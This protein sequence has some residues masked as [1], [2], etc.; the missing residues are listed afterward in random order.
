MNVNVYTGHQQTEQ[1]LTISGVSTLTVVADLLT[2]ECKVDPDIG[3]AFYAHHR[4]E[5]GQWTHF[6]VA[7]T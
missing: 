1:P 2:I 5:R 4:F 6:E 3:H 7:R